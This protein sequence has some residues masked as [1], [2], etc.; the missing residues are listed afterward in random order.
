MHLGPTVSRENGRAIL[1]PYQS[2]TGLRWI[3]V[4]LS[5]GDRH[6]CDADLMHVVIERL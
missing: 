3:T 4:K 6:L 2:G 5:D 1:E